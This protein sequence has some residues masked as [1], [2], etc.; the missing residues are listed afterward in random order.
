MKNYKETFGASILMLIIGI[1]P[2]LF[3][4]IIRI[5]TGSPTSEQYALPICYLI[6][7][8]LVC[9]ASK[10]LI[11]FNIKNHIRKPE[12]KTLFL[13]I[14]TALCYA[15]ADIYIVNR[16]ALLGNPQTSYS[17]SEIYTLVTTAFL[18]PVSEELIF[19]LGMLSLLI[20]GACNSKIKYIISAV[21]I[22]IPWL[23]IHFPKNHLRII[24]IIIVSI[25]ISTIYIL[26][27]NIIYCIAFHMT[28]NCLTML[29]AVTYG[30]FF[31][32]EYILYIAIAVLAIA[33]PAM[34]V[35]IYKKRN[36]H[37][38]QPLNT[39]KKV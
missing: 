31:A 3:D 16:A 37:D 14:T 34:F 32:R 23:F 38:F 9:I 10:K 15:A 5:V 30:F 33:M 20:I 12:L 29:S 35:Y 39:L 6:G 28:A 36:E 18:A 22:T 2:L 1:C 26:T 24:D 19:R 25:I 17:N 13:I 21:L 4:V 27:K 11:N 8:I 7:G